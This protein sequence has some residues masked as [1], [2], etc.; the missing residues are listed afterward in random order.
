MSGE[1]N[2]RLEYLNKM[3]TAK[4]LAQEGFRVFKR[5]TPIRKGN[6]RRKTT[7]KNDEIRADYPYAGKLDDGYSKQSPLGMTKPAIEHVQQYIR[8][9]G[10][11]GI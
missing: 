5:E 8:D 10:H 4:K 1:I 7:L 2:R 9:I 6:A 11:K 3:L